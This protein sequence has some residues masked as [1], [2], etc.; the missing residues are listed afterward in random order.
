METSNP[1]S[2]NELFE[3]WKSQFRK[4][5]LELFLLELLTVEER[6]YGLALMERMRVSGVDVSEG[7]LYPLLMRMTREGSIVSEWETPEVGHPRKYYRVTG[8]G[9]ELLEA[10]RGE[11]DRSGI[12]LEAVTKR[13]TTL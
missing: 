9:T 10:M 4:G 11:Y 7:T 6:S 1:L 3:K 12:S 2:A 8:C 5:F 13:R